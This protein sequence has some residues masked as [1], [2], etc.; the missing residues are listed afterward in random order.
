MRRDGD[1]TTLAPLFFKQFL[2][3]IESGE[4]TVIV[5][6]QVIYALQRATPPVS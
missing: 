6:L 3:P 5:M 4:G 2:T 1:L